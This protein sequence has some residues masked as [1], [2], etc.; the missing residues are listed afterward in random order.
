MSASPPKADISGVLSDVRFVPKADIAAEG[1]AVGI[2]TVGLLDP[3][4]RNW[5]HCEPVFVV[6]V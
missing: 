3:G 6:V 5:P 2:A 4:Q 1:S